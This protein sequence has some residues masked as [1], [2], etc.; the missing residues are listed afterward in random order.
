MCSL[1]SYT[2]GPPGYGSAERESPSLDRAGVHSGVEQC[3]PV[4][5]IIDELDDWGWLVAV[6][7]QLDQLVYGG[8][9]A[10]LDA[11]RYAT[12]KLVTIEVRVTDEG[13]R[14]ERFAVNTLHSQ[15]HSRYFSV[16]VFLF[17]RMQLSVWK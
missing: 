2:L 3:A 6:R 12:R 4:E 9:V 11:L 1:R 5:Y 14:C 7:D 10:V 13:E 17:S 16:Y 8:D 15:S